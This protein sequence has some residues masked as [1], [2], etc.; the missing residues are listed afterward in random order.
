M[1]DGE[2]VMVGTRRW[3]CYDVRCAWA[4]GCVSITRFP[5]SPTPPLSHSLLLSHS[6]QAG[7]GSVLHSVWLYLIKTA[8]TRSFSFISLPQVIV[9]PALWLSLLV[10]R[11]R[12]GMEHKLL[13][14]LVLV[15]WVYLAIYI[16][17]MSTGRYLVP[18]IPLLVLFFIQFLRNMPERIASAIIISGLTLAAVL[19]SVWYT[20]VY[21]LP[22]L[23]LNAVIFGL[24]GSYIVSQVYHWRYRYLLAAGCV[25]FIALACTV[26]GL[27]SSYRIGQIGKFPRYGYNDEIT[28][29][30]AELPVGERVYV[31][32]FVSGGLLNFYYGLKSGSA[33]GTW[34]LREWLPK[35]QLLITN[36]SPLAGFRFYTIERFRTAIEEKGIASI[37][38]LRRAGD[39]REKA[40]A[41]RR[42][43]QDI[44]EECLQADWLELE[45]KVEFRNKTLYVFRVKVEV[46]EGD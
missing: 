42:T 13:L 5:H 22:R 40:S 33:E 20:P 39:N 34:Y 19:F 23:V 27:A 24:L 41:T 44:L 6:R 25:L 4:E 30:V 26:T 1:A 35:S 29:T 3:M 46:G 15:L 8:G 9:F 28:R 10:F 18:V 38:I 12:R 2:G 37:V 43:R 14:P 21:I 11:K 31:S 45:R 32:G 17:R 7:F 16:V 36:P